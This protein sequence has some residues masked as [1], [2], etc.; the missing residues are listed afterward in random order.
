M[1]KERKNKAFCQYCRRYF[2]YGNEDLIT[3]PWGRYALCPH[4][5]TAVYKVKEVEHEP[6]DAEVGA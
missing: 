2:D 1:S 4:C 3:K 5:G 6:E